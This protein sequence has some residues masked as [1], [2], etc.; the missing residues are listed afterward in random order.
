MEWIHFRTYD[1]IPEAQWVQKFL[2]DHGIDSDIRSD[3]QSGLYPSISF[4]SGVKVYL[5]KDQHRKAKD[6]LDGKN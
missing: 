4:I 2:A 3:D 5:P 6:L 1:S